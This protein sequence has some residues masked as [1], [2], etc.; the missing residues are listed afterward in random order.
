MINSDI[1]ERAR[2]NEDDY[3]RRRDAELLASAKAAARTRELESERERER[4]ALGTALGLHDP[5]VVIPLYEAGVRAESIGVLEWLPAIEVAWV[6]G[7]E[8]PERD[9]LSRQFSESAGADGAGVSLI[10]H[11]LYSRP[12]QE[13]LSAAR[14]AL[15][16][17]LT[18]LDEDNRQALLNRVSS[19]CE[20]VGRAAGGWFGIGMVSAD[21]RQHIE[22][23][24]ESLGDPTVAEDPLPGELPH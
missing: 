11:W 5:A 9:E 3:F 21:E 17:R 19:R 14:H 12:P 15:R 4:Q 2:R 22:H 13:A 16:H 10:H 8:M 24:R 7:V 6:D 20:I 1:H 18:Q 23:I